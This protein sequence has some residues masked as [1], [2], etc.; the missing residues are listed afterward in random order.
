[1]TV[2]ISGITSGNRTITYAKT[3]PSAK[4][5]DLGEKAAQRIW[6]MGFG[7]HGTFESPVLFSQLSNAQKMVVL[8]EYLTHILRQAAHE[9]ER[10]DYER[11]FAASDFEMGL[12]FKP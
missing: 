12:L 3:A 9:Q 4:M 10:E 2:T 11:A 7:E 6:N 5:L 8:D 1:M